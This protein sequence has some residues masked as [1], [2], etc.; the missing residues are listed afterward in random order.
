MLLQNVAKLQIRW[1]MVQ[2]G[3]YGKSCKTELTL[4]WVSWRWMKKGN[5][6]SAQRVDSSDP[7]GGGHQQSPVKPQRKGSAL[8]CPP[9]FVQGRGAVWQGVHSLT[10]PAAGPALLQQ[11]SST[12]CRPPVQIPGSVSSLTCEPPDLRSYMGLA[13]SEKT[14][15]TAN[16]NISFWITIRLFTL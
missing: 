12:L 10:S 16:R 4:I 9:R 8:V 15:R 2:K 5:E 11:W 13:C 1:T 14:A 7:R 3:G 6:P